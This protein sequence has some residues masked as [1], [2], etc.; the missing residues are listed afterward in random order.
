[1]YPQY[2]KNNNN[3]D[4]NN[5]ENTIGEKTKIRSENI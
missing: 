2:N 3:S 4:N 5:K 1:M